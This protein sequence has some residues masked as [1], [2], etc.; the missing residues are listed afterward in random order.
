MSAE[1]VRDPHVGEPGEPQRDGTAQRDF[2]HPGRRDVV[3]G[4][5]VDAGQVPGPGE[6][7]G[8]HPQ[9]GARDDGERPAREARRVPAGACG[10]GGLRGIAG[11]RAPPPPP[12]EDNGQPDEQRPHQELLLHGQRPV[13][14]EG[15]RGALGGQVVGRGAGK[16]PV[17]HVERGTDG[18]ARGLTAWRC[19]SRTMAA[20]AVTSTTRADA[21]SSRRTRRPQ[22]RPTARQPSGGSRSRCAV[23]R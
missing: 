10:A 2:P 5:R 1:P 9:D 17:L 18:L 3:R 8:E 13:V 14:P 21:G 4:C 22:K 12:A 23:M 20:A 16:H 6:R 19:G 11:V 7:H 15:G